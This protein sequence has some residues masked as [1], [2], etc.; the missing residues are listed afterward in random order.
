MGVG[1]DALSVSE[2]HMGG[3]GG[4]RRGQMIFKVP[5]FLTTPESVLSSSKTVPQVYHQVSSQDVS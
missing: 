3:P 4:W 5:Q 1:I 2:G